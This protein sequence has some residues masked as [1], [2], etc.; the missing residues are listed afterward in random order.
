MSAYYI[1]LNKPR[2]NIGKDSMKGSFLGPS[3]SQNNVEFSLT[4]CGAI[5]ETLTHEEIIE[6]TAYALA[7]GKAIGWMNGR[8]EFGPRS[9]GGR[10][11]IADPRSASMQKKL[12]LKVKFRE[13]FRPF[14]PSILIEDVDKWFQINCE[15]PYMLFV[16]ELARDKR[17]EM[18]KNENALFG[19]DK[20]NIERSDISAVTH[21]DYSARIQTVSK[22]TNPSFYSLIK[23]FKKITGCPVLV[24]TSFNIRGEPIICSPEDAFKCFMGTELDL[25]IIENSILYKT[26]QTQVL[27]ATY[28]TEYELD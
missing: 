7:D 26:K 17:K 9:L 1:M 22:E 13:S 12:N 2:K 6:Q 11:I 4:K 10:S 14:A 28:K 3:Y 19:I 5:F 16:A 20:L 25:L 27:S 15:S 8:M 18:T 21:V 23:K 24:N